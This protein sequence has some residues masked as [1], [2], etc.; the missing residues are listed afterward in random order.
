VLL[1]AILSISAAVYYLNRRPGKRGRAA[2]VWFYKNMNDI[3]ARKGIKRPPSVT[4]AE[5]AAILLAEKGRAYEK[6][7][8]ITETYNKVRFGGRSVG[9]DESAALRE[10]LDMLSR[11]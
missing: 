9:K 1:S 8:Y 5:F 4:P 3:L 2:D 11:N 6:V 10:A 7:L